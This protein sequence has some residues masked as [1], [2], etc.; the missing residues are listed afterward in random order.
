MIA[1]DGSPNRLLRGIYGRDMKN[2][3]ISPLSASF[4][5]RGPSIAL[6]GLGMALDLEN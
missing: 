1:D 5:R 2:G 4:Y 3:V 6:G